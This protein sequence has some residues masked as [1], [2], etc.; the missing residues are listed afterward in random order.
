MRANKTTIITGLMLTA[1]TFASARSEQAP[2]QAARHI[3]LQE[4]IDLSLKASKQLRVSTARLQQA[5]SAYTEAKDRRLPDVSVTGSYI[6]LAQPDIELKLKLGSG[7]SGTGGGTAE[8]S[9]APATPTQAAY[10]IA[11]VSLPLFTGFK[12]QSGI[13]SAKYLALASK[14]DAEKDRDD[15][16][17][18]TIAAYTNLYKATEAVKQVQENLKSAGQRV[19]ELSR[20]EQNGLLARNDLLKAQ[21]Q[22][23][24]VEL[25]LLDAENNLRVTTENM[26]LMLGLPE[27]TVIEPDSDFTTVGGNRTLSEW[28]SLALEN[29]KD[30]ASLGYRAKAAEAGVRAAKGDYYPSLALTGGYIGAYVENIITIKDAVNVGVGFS[31]KPSSIW[32]NSNNVSQAKQRLIEVQANQA[33]LEDAI[34]LQTA[35]AYEAYL[36]SVKKIDV[37]NKAVAQAEEN[38]RIV[39]N[40]YTNSLATTTELLDADVAQLQARL[41]Y[42]FAKAD[43]LVS[44]HRLL[45]TA[46]IL[47]SEGIAGK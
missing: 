17:Q 28:E 29:R 31:Y 11:N 35:Q 38:N 44:Y 27:E 39:R 9:S 5:Q 12:I 19:T 32:K 18:N 30:A 13:E 22:S 33:L 15:V 23:S 10:A 25:T 20:L 7:S 42:A 45:Q 40:K 34:R 37:Y 6:R 8:Q 21:L 36:L 1:A 3:S 24:N 47:S 26:N 43:A 16:I 41:N 14:L 4:A 46:G 2:M